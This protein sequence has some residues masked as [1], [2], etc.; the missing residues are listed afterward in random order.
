M[1]EALKELGRL[2]L[3]NE[4]KDFVESLV[5]ELPDSKKSSPHLVFIN[6][7]TKNTGSSFLEIKLNE[8]NK[9]IL[10]EYLWVGNADGPNSPQWY[11][12]TDKLEYL[13][14]Q[15]IP[16]LIT[17]LP[18]DSLLKNDLEHCWKAFYVDLGKQKGQKERYRYIFDVSRINSDITTQDLYLQKKNDV[19]KTVNEVTK[20]FYDFIK[21]QLGLTK[22]E[23]RLFTLLINGKPI[24]LNKEYRNLVAH[25]KVDA[26]F[27]DSQKGTCGA[28]GL[29]KP[30][31]SNTT[32]LKFKYYIT[33]KLNFAHGL[34]KKNFT[35]NLSLCS[36]CYKQLLAAEALVIKFLS[37]RIGL[38]AGGL[39]L[40][41]IP[42]FLFEFNLNYNK[43]EQW[44][45]DIKLKFE[46]LSEFNEK[47]IKLEERFESHQ[48]RKA[49]NDNYILNFLFYQRSQAELKVLDLIQDVPPSRLNAIGE[50]TS[51]IHD[52]GNQLLGES[53][54]WILDFNKI[55]YL[56]PPKYDKKANKAIQYRE[57]LQIFESI[58]TGKPLDYNLVM[59]E[60]L[61]LIQLHYYGR[62]E[63]YRFAKPKDVEDQ[64]IQ[65]LF[66]VLRAN[67][68]MAYAR[69][70]RIMDTGGII[71]DVSNWFVEESIKEYI[72]E[73]GFNECQSG[74]FLL[75]YLLGEVA[76]AQYSENKKSK[77]VLSKLNYQGMDLKRIY[78][79]SLEI[80][81]KLQQYKKLDP[82]TEKIHAQFKKIM[83]KHIKNWPLSHI[84]NVF[85]I[86]SGYAFN[87]YRIIRI[88]AESE[89]RK[90][91]EEF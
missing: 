17:K 54:H 45:N 79:L 7:N 48:E 2:A 15:T 35:T 52:L 12:T 88:A 69:K 38:G 40:Y 10:T 39:S 49:K 89:K 87:T 72:K 37:T 13:L 50:V 91:K 59:K 78:I 64:F 70:L 47:L 41:I 67:L 71:V 19:K 42:G 65:L 61:E 16:N 77:P 33:D 85:Y 29:N 3:E 6:F 68:F 25:E 27:S 63:Q 18:D 36:P 14:S 1:I 73:V 34:N 4:Q 74:L 44:L 9:N 46:T 58:F 32:R 11:V 83:D 30:V 23:A 51:R 20:I 81:E 56:F 55:Y 60:F 86:L 80:F 31:T 8:I 26:L 76:N 66:A 28:C 53:R 57:I 43:L 90:K 5:L 22:E 82:K 75:G 21:K 84:E 24:A 62:Y